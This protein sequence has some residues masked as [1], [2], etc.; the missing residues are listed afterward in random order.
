MLGKLTVPDTT[1]AHPVVIYVQTAEGATVDMKRP[2]GRNATFNFYDLYRE[3]LPEMNVAFFSYEGRGIRMGDAPPR[4]EA[5]DADVYNTSTLENKVRD[6]LSAI[7]VVK[8]QKGINPDRILL[9]GA[10]EGTLLC[11]DAVARAP[12]D[13]KG[14]VLYGILSSTLKDMLTYM[15]EE[16]SFVNINAM[17]DTDKDGK[18]SRAEFD[19]D[20]GKNREQALKG[21]TFETLDVSRDG[22]FT[23]DDLRVL[24]K[25][26][27]DGIA[28][29]NYEVYRRIPETDVG[30]QLA[31]RLGSGPF[32]PPD[33]VERLVAAFHSRGTVSRECRSQHAGVRN[34]NAR[35]TGQ[36]S[37]QNESGI[38][39]LRRPRSQPWNRIMVRAETPRKA[40]K[41]SSSSFTSDAINYK[42]RDRRP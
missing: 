13:V 5:I 32:R 6:I 9:M 22:F 1:G 11:A 17:F 16:A 23:V 24:R 8:R 19:A 41:R 35:R 2:L 34:S 7:E 20:P 33:D 14:L 30:C 25:P 3:K 18:T 36:S 10:S 38:P 27:L 40:T 4:Y 15:A 37:R 39:L 29:N 31:P 12:A 26:L 21:V 42:A 28:A